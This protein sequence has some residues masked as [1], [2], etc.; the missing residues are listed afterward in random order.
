MFY[1]FLLTGYGGPHAGFFAVK[2]SLLRSLPGRIVGKTKYVM[3]SVA[4]WWNVFFHI[5]ATLVKN[6][7]SK[8]KG[9]VSAGSELYL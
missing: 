5:I 2:R 8:G 6:F 7:C 1:I 9:L 4:V 3:L